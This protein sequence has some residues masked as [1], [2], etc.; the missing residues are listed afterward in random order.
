MRPPVVLLAATACARLHVVPPLNQ[1]RMMTRKSTLKL[2]YVEGRLRLAERE[3]HR[4]SHSTGTAT[5]S[6]PSSA[7]AGPGPGSTLA[8]TAPGAAGASSGAG[9]A[10]PA[11]AAGHGTAGFP[12]KYE[13][14]SRNR[15]QGWGWDGGGQRCWPSATGGAPCVFARWWLAR[16]RAQPRTGSATLELSWRWPQACCISPPPLPTTLLPPPPA[17]SMHIHSLICWSTPDLPVT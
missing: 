6:M 9:A 8:G 16:S 1:V 4:T 5:K 3:R 11:S 14:R 12:P 7:G 13:V 2:S 10:A 15:S 17:H